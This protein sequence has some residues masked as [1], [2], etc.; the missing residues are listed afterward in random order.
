MVNS[1]S[2]VNGTRQLYDKIEIHVRGL[3]TLGIDSSQYGS[4]LVPVLLNKIPQ[5]LRLIISR[6]FSSNTWNLDEL[7][8]VIKS[9]VEAR[10]RCS[11]MTT[12]HATQLRKGLPRHHPITAQ[13]LLSSEAP[14]ITCTFCK[15]SHRSVD[16]KVV[17]SVKQRKEIVKKQG[18]CF[19]CLKRTHL[20][21]DCGSKSSCFKCSQR[22]HPSLC[23]RSATSAGN[24][25][26]TEGHHP[27][28]CKEQ[29]SSTVNMYVESKTAIL[30][31]TCVALASNPNSEKSQNCQ[32]VRLILDSGSQKT[33]IT[34]KLRET[35]GL[36]PVAREKLCIKTFGSDF[37][38]I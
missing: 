32:R 11:V 29:S 37:S 35:L 25:T 36:K 27:M 9:E 3:Q 21:R 20:A 19:V 13:A 12:T 18:R 1:V 15:Q 31:Q 8:R 17:T 24:S 5:E 30:L 6:K 2:D 16:C 26:D 7:L 38:S 22:H 4:L 34:Q 33:Y 23:T 10:E 14:N 28:Q